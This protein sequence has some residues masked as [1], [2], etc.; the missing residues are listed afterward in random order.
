MKRTALRRGELWDAAGGL[1]G[2]MFAE[3]PMCCAF[4]DADRAKIAA[5]SDAGRLS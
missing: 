1:R 2:L 5:T 3:I 4:G